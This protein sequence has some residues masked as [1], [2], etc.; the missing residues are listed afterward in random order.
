[1]CIHIMYNH[2]Q[3][4]IYSIYTYAASQ[5]EVIF[6]ACIYSMDQDLLAIES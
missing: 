5:I 4:S 2:V 1:M 3:Y 6:F